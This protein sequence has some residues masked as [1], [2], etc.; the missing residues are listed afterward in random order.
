MHPIQKPQRAKVAPAFL[1]MLI[2]TPRQ[3][4]KNIIPTMRNHRLQRRQ[5]PET[6][7]GKHMAVQQLWRQPQRQ[8]RADQV[9]K[10]MSILSSQCDRSFELM[11]LVVDGF[12][13]RW[14]VE[15]AV[16]VV[17]EEFADEYACNYISGHLEKAGHCVI[18]AIE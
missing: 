12:V 11:V 6:P 10:R 5:C 13:A 9:F 15:E 14:K 3:F 16:G 1:M 8:D 4:P 18:E 17:E 7:S 2:M